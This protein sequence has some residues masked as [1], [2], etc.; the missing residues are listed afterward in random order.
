MKSSKFK[1]SD[2]FADHLGLIPDK[3]DR[4]DTT[5]LEL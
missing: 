1:C 2:M 4:L 5:K 3:N